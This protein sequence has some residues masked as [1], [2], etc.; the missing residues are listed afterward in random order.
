M[1]TD[2]KHDRLMDHNYDGI[3]EYDNPL[4]AWWVLFFWA[5]ILFAVLY[6]FNVPGFG[7]GHGR[8]ANYEREMAAAHAKFGGLGGGGNIS[9]AAILAAAQDKAQLE[10]GKKTFTTI[11]AACH[12][13]DGGGNIGPNL[14]DEYWL[15]GGKPEQIYSTVWNGVP[16]KGM[17]TW[18]ASLKPDQ[19]LHVVAYV[20]TLKGT[21]P[22]N[23]K[24]PQGVKE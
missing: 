8:I 13:P 14:T 24:A 11:C 9:P 2:P 12:R 4:P 6:W 19:I 3:Q 18:S 5:T 10:D 23:P 17:P 16:A 7:I 15:H 21:N 1:T 22:P 20:T